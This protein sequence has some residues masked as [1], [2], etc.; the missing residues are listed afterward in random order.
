MSDSTW[1]LDKF[2]DSLLGN[3]LRGPESVKY[4]FGFGI[5]ILQCV[6]DMHS[7]TLDNFN[8]VLPRNTRQLRYFL[9]TPASSRANSSRYFVTCG[10]AG[11]VRTFI[12]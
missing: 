8:A 11:S 5:W 7:D 12:V 2:T 3:L 4:S 9:G 6:L 1:F 10:E